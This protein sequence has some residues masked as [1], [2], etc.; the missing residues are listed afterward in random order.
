MTVLHRH[1][2]YQDQGWQG[3]G[4][5]IDKEIVEMRGGHIWVE[6]IVIVGTHRTPSLRRHIDGVDPAGKLETFPHLR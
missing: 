1:G 2:R 3:L 5:A 4:L 6:S